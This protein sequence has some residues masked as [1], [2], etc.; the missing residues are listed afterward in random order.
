MRIKRM[1]LAVRSMWSVSI[2][3]GGQLSFGRGAGG[4]ASGRR[5]VYGQFTAG[6]S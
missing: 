2:E 5:A 3:T 6:V 1:Q 4:F